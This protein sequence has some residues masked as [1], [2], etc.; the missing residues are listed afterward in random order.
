MI[1][2]SLRGDDEKSRKENQNY[3][4]SLQSFYQC[5]YGKTY[6]QIT[7][8]NSPDFTGTFSDEFSISS[9]CGRTG[10]V[11]DPFISRG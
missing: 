8:A 9:R 3:Y 6:N 10:H 1:V 5:L 2:S 7:K 4:F 11:H